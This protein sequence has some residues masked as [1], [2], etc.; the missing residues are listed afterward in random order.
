MKSRTAWLLIAVSLTAGF[1]AGKT[2]SGETSS[3]PEKPTR[4][5]TR[6]T[7]SVR[8]S[9]TDPFGGP[10]FSL[11]S[12]EDVEALFKKQ[13]GAVANAR[14]TLG[15]EKLSSSELAEVMEMIQQDTREKPGYAEGRYQLMNSVFEKWVLVDPDAAL[16]FANSCKQR[17]FKSMAISSCFAGLAQADPGRAKL[18]LNQLPK[19]EIRKQAGQAIISSL[20]TRDPEAALDLLEKEPSPGGFGD[21][22]ASQALA[23]WAK[24]D[25]KA[26]AARLASLPKDRVDEDSA[27]AVA[28]SWAKTDPEAA[29]AW[30]KTQKGDWKNS[31]TQSVYRE[32]ALND[33]GAAWERL[34]SEPGHLRGKLLGTVLEIVSDENP[35]QALALLN[36]LSNKSE[37]RIGA[38]SLV[39]Q[40]QWWGGDNQEL[41]FKVIAGMEDSD[42]RRNLLGEQLWYLSWTSP[43]TLAEKVSTLSEREKIATAD[44]ILRGMLA[45]DPKAAE[46]YF[47]SLP[48][49]QRGTEA[50]TEMMNRYA[51]LDPDKAFQFALSLQNSQERT[52]AVTGLFSQW[53]RED[54]EAAAEGW[55]KIPAGQSRLEALDQI[56]SS[57]ARNDPEE[58]K[59]WAQSLSGNERVRALAA[60]LPS[61][62]SDHPEN[63]AS[64]LST[65]ISSAPDGLGGNLAQSAGRVASTWAADQPAAASRWAAGLPEGPAR[66]EGLK[67][68]SMAWSQYDAV[69]TAEWLGTLEAGSSRDA[70]IE[71]LVEHVRDT[72]P[73]TAFSWA[74]SIGDKNDRF[75]QLRET[76]KTWRATDLQA[77]RAAFEAAD[78]SP[79]DRERLGKVLE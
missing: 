20:A 54:P 4:S 7:K 8:P 9:R 57:W 56:A 12:M 14:I 40:L 15:V 69:A 74:A 16:A 27:G 67:A 79:K 33:S 63:A 19:G 61:V 6:E 71:P 42:S 39:N 22:Y 31:A 68:V 65:L 45:S 13:R 59:I 52:A 36:S 49:A 21:Y 35:N 75:N 43:D 77:A 23:E 48:E 64:T 55:T 41:A 5:E 34:K 53:S 18:E 58:A 25:P 70:A 24:K 60:V 3:A 30:A 50:L 72:D 78:L 32:L 38:E 10:E 26:A 46:A 51:N 47:L 11:K 62:A 73:N 28:A 29:L 17:S 37:K 44:Q 1:F 66:D 2:T 76:L